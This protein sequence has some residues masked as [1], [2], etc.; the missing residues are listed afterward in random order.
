MRGRLRGWSQPTRIPTTAPGRPLECLEPRLL[1]TASI[2]NVIDD[3][4]LV[5]TDPPIGID[6][7]N[8]FEDDATS[9][10]FARFDSTQGGFFI[11]L[12]ED[13]TPITTANFRQYVRDGDYTDSL[14]HRAIAGF[15][16]QGG[17]FFFSDSVSGST[18]VEEIPT[19]DPIENEFD[20]WFDSDF[21]DREEGTPI[22]VRGTVAMAKLGG[23]ADSATSQ[24]FVNLDDN[25]AN[26]DSQ[27]GGFTAFGQVLFNGFDVFDAIAALPLVNQGSPFESMP[28]RNYVDGDEVDKDSNGVFVHTAEIDDL[29]FEVVT[30]SN[31]EVLA[32]TVNVHGQLSLEPQTTTGGLAMITV[33]A[34]DLED[35]T[36]ADQTFTITVDGPP[37]AVDDRGTNVVANDAIV[38]DVLTNDITAQPFDLATLTVIDN[39]THG[40]AVV[41]PNNWFIT[42]TPDG[43][44]VTDTFTYQI[45]DNLGRLSNVAEVFLSVETSPMANPD[46][47]T[48]DAASTP[49]VIHVLANDTDLNGDDTINPTTVTIVDQPDDGLVEVDP[50]T[51]IVTYTPSDDLGGDDSFSY[52]VTDETDR[53]SNEATVDISVQIPPVAND[54]EVSVDIPADP[55]DIDVLDNDTDDNGDDTIDPGTVEIVNSGQFLFGFNLDFEIPA[56]SQDEFH[57]FVDALNDG[58]MPDNIKQEFENNGSPLSDAATV[59]VE[60]EGDRWLIDDQG[61]RYLVLDEFY[62]QLTVRRLDIQD[63]LD[64]MTVSDDLEQA[65]QAN[66]H[67]LTDTATV[68]VKEP[69]HRWVINDQGSRFLLR[70]DESSLDVSDLPIEVDPGTGVLTFTPGADL[71]NLGGNVSFEYTVADIRGLVSNNAKLDIAIEAAPVANDDIATNDNLDEDI[72][73]GVLS[74]DT[75]ANGD[76]TIDVATVTFIDQ[77]AF[78]EIAKNFDTGIVTYTP[79]ND[80]LGDDTFTYTVADESERESNV[81]TVTISVQI[82]P[83][84]ENDNIVVELNPDGSPKLDPIVFDLLANDTDENGNDTIDPSTVAIVDQPDNGVVAVDPNTGEITFTPAAD[85]DGGTSFTYRVSDLTDPTPLLS[86]TATVEVGIPEGSSFGMFDAGTSLTIVIN[87]V[88]ATFNLKGPGTGDVVAGGGPRV[89][90]ALTG[91]DLSST[92]TITTSGG[93][94]VFVI[95]DITSDNPL[96]SLIARTT[97][98]GGKIDIDGTATTIVIADIDSNHFINI[99]A[100]IAANNAVS[101]VFGTVRDLVINTQTRIKS[102][103][104]E[105]WFDSGGEGDDNDVINAPSISALKIANQ[106][107]ADLNLDASLGDKVTL[108][109]AVIGNRLSNAA[110]TILGHVGKIQTTSVDNFTLDVDRIADGNAQVKLLDLGR[111]NS[112]T[113]VDV[114]GDIN[115]IK[116]LD[117]LGI[118]SLIDAASLRRIEAKGQVRNNIKGKLGVD[119]NLSGP[120]KAKTRLGRARVT[121]GLTKS[122]WTIDGNLPRLG[123]PNTTNWKLNLTGSLG[124]L[125]L[126]TALRTHLDIAGKIGRVA[127]E[128]WATGSIKATS[129]RVIGIQ[130][131]F[132]RGRRP[133]TMGADITLTG[134]TTEK[135]RLG[136]ARIFGSIT[137]GDWNIDGDTRLISALSWAAGTFTGSAIVKLLVNGPI[138]GGFGQFEADL[139]LAGTTNAKTRLGSGKISGIIDNSTWVL[140]GPAG[141]LKIGIGAENWVAN[142]AGHVQLLQTKGFLSS[143]LAAPSFGKILVGTDMGG[144]SLLAGTDLG[145]DVALD[146]TDGNDDTYGPGE[147]NRLAVRG[148]VFDSI[149]GAGLDPVDGEFNNG[150]DVVVGGNQ[151]MINSIVI[152]D[153]VGGNTLFAAGV[154]GNRIIIDGR[155]TDTTTS[156]L[157][158]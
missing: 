31:P 112:N 148:A 66:E 75:D 35:E 77:P 125:S 108:I 116:V 114:E 151:S 27:N 29:R 56:S 76:D 124:H 132:N 53:L 158:L 136:A 155:P 1:L 40:D 36:S 42:Y 60:A 113:M 30:N 12:F 104:A 71:G 134:P 109:S 45:A 58:I 73:I 149:I 34:T 142:F 11:E 115:Q 84:A 28:L 39:P 85:F 153:I 79:N 94:N 89:D 90:M 16:V 13:I 83:A 141:P 23:D 117:W 152:N 68:T 95:N 48:S 63:T 22:N 140:D 119:L 144:A 2:T 19:D 138:R 8:H 50:V 21:G 92:V 106:F 147:I 154:Y 110:W 49:I 38:V 65:F 33:R 128:K 72:V 101:F 91:T 17:G 111:A 93:D 44:L 88:T 74:N 146:G 99:G 41:D 126:G 32:A 127:A 4:A 122:T 9:D 59:V 61:T 6:L 135:Y 70:F 67:L 131:T 46:L 97:N 37:N 130:G 20:N 100:A 47:G 118:D 69:G 123:L 137:G 78:G 14:F 143:V 7:K 55:F 129:A 102:L 24:W 107:Q 26:L 80:F 86:N 64:T 18:S 133:S 150:D 82:P 157:F 105:A 96:G 121:Q 120:T 15:V 87:G 25:S 81:A 3:Q 139:T 145:N 156:P 52:T 43:D 10:L 62:G 57:E 103:T 51:G 5:F 54:D 98:L